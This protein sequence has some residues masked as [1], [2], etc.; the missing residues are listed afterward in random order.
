MKTNEEIIKWIREEIQWHRNM[1]VGAGT[2]YQSPQ[3]R[4]ECEHVDG[5]LAELSQSFE[6]FLKKD[7]A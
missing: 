3:D 5:I 1:A 6:S 2:I 4:A 7:D